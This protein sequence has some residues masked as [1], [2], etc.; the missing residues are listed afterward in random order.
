M[1]SSQCLENP[2]TLSPTCGAG[3]V[4]ELGGL[5]TYVTGPSDSKLAI[6]LISDIFGNNPSL[7]SFISINLYKLYGSY[8]VY[9]EVGL[10]FFGNWYAFFELIL[11]DISFSS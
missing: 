7:H 3:T 5:N 6:L 10:P 4:Q 11:S 2:P 9:F 1:A 8:M